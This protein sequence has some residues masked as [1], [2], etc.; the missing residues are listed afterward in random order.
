MKEEQ[1]FGRV[2]DLPVME[3]S[4]EEHMNQ[5]NLWQRYRVKMIRGGATP[6]DPKRDPALTLMRQKAERI[7]EKVQ[8]AERYFQELLDDQDERENDITTVD[9]SD[10]EIDQHE[11]LKVS[12]ERVGILQ[13]H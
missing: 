3:F 7:L 5:P 13:R 10:E 12:E 11:L 1:L 8:L 2:K 9:E 4:E 6:E